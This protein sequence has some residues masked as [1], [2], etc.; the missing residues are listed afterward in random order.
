MGLPLCYISAFHVTTILKFI[1]SLRIYSSSFGH[2]EFWSLWIVS[3]RVS[4]RP[5]GTREASQAHHVTNEIKE[6]IKVIEKIVAWKKRDKNVL[7][8]F[9]LNTC[10]SE[11][12]RYLKISRSFTHHKHIRP[13]NE[14]KY[15]GVGVLPEIKILFTQIHILLKYHALNYRS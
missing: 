5:C 9:Y 14:W 6:V 13:D 3:Y 15:L 12:I 7:K 8:W 10:Y 1:W 2:H 4:Y 11:Q